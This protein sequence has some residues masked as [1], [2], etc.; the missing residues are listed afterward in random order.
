[1]DRK[2]LQKLARIRLKEARVLLQNKC[3]DGAYYLCG[4]ALECAIKACIAK[5][6]KRGEFPN[7]QLANESFSHDLWKLLGVAGLRPLFEQDLS[8]TPDL[9]LNWAVA[10]DWSEE[11]RYSLHA[12]QKARDLYKAVRDPKHGVFR[13]IRQHW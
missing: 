11:A 5:K 7:K 12:E 10:K 2:D 6:T 13:W 9:K 8:T 4:Y 3:F 1:M